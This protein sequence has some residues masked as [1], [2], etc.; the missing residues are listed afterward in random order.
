MS[1]TVAFLMVRSTHN[2]ILIYNQYCRFNAFLYE[3][4]NRQKKGYWGE[5][6]SN[7]RPQDHSEAMRPTR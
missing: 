2:Y 6:G 7:S 5:R 3:K 4:T 1:K